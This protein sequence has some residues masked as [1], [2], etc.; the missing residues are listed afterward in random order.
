MHAG[1][2]LIHVNPDLRPRTEYILWTNAY[3]RCLMLRDNM[4]SPIKLTLFQY[5]P[6]VSVT[7]PLL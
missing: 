7:F 5:L 1:K 4:C 3:L 6:R 2:D